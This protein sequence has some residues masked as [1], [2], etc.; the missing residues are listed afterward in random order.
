VVQLNYLANIRIGTYHDI[1]INYYF[2][3]DLLSGED[4]TKWPVVEATKDEYPSTTRNQDIAEDPEADITKVSNKIDLVA[5]SYR[6]RAGRRGYTESLIDSGCNRL[7]FGNRELFQDFVETLIPIKTA[8]NT[9]YAMGVGTV[10]KLRGCLYVPNLP[11][12]LISPFQAMGDIN[13]LTIGLELNKW[14]LWHKLNKFV[15]IVIDVPDRL[16]EVTDYSW[17]G[18]DEWD[19]EAIHDRIRDKSVAMRS[20][21]IT[22]VTSEAMLEQVY[23]LTEENGEAWMT[24]ERQDGIVGAYLERADAL[25]LLHIRLGHMPYQQIEMMIRR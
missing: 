1:A 17:M 9:I 22:G 23:L 18:I 25:E 12:N 10:G 5:M 2:T 19:E 16:I 14:T 3:D 11:I 21:Y 4:T 8:G 20:E 24:E 6:A 7:M 13:G 15:P